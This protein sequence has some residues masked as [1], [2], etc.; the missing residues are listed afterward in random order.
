VGTGL[1]STIL[2]FNELDGLIQNGDVVL[3]DVGGQYSGY[4]ADITRTV[5]ANG[6]FTPRQREIYE[7]VLGAQNAALAAIKPGTTMRKGSGSLY[8]IAYDYINTHG[9]DREGR[10]LGRYFTHG[11][12][13]H[14]GLEVHDAG[15]VDRPFE[16]GMV[17]TDE[18]GI[19]IPE[20]KIG[21]RIEDDVLVTPTGYKLLTARLPRSADE[22]EKI[23]ADSQVARGQK[24]IEH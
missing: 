20:E 17:I 11:L 21:V 5:P 3:M 7:I 23:M 12:G 2:H 6:H 9:T 10:S 18:P 24:S 8:K 16:A 4:T 13:H 15:D 14:I 22:I 19:Y 1:H